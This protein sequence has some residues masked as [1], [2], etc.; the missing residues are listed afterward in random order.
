MISHCFT[1]GSLMC[2]DIMTLVS[3]IA[4]QG[5]RAF[6]ADHAR[7]PVREEDYPGM[8]ARPGHRV[9]GVL[10][11]DLPAAAWPRLDRFEG[12]MYARR[13]VCVQLPGDA[14]VEAWTYLFKPAYWDLLLPDEW[15]FNRFLAEGK[16]RF[17]HRY[18]GYGMLE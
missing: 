12:A 4:V 16:A 2:A 5:E 17:T 10:Y 18:L 8:V 3:G 9:E 6:L 15:D 1:Y 11:R 14:R 7:H 13:L